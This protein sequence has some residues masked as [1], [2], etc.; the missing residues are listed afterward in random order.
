MLS[1]P[2]AGASNPPP[3][4]GRWSIQAQAAA[5]QRPSKLPPGPLHELPIAGSVLRIW[6]EDESVMLGQWQNFLLLDA[7][8]GA[9]RPEHVLLQDDI[10]DRMSDEH[11]RGG[12]KIVLARTGLRLPCESMNDVFLRWMERNARYLKAYALLPEIAGFQSAL[13]RGAVSRMFMSMHNPLPMRVLGSPEETS[14]WILPAMREAGQNVSPA[15]LQALLER[16]LEQRGPWR[17]C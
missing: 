14:E 6:H 1:G 15:A 17:D 4:P 5:Q 16:M 7:R 9:P 12:A 2:P 10:L 3:H 11:P 13:L 8:N